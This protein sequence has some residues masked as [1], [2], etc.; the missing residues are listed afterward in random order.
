MVRST[1]AKRLIIRAEASSGAAGWTSQQHLNAY[2]EEGSMILVVLEELLR[3]RDI[4]NGDK[5][6]INRDYMKETTLMKQRRKASLK[7]R[8]A[9]P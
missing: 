6:A 3:I 7:S 9:K 1:A 5:D 8:L 4:L 2:E